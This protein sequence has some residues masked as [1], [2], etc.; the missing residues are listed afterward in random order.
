MSLKVEMNKKKLVVILVT[1]ALFLLMACEINATQTE[2]MMKH[3]SSKEK[4]VQYY[5]KNEKVAGSIDLITTTKG[6]KLLVTER[7]K[8]LL[9]IGQLMKDRKGYY[10]SKITADTLLNTESVG[11]ELDTMDDHK[12][13]IYFTKTNDNS[14]FILL[15]N[16]EFYFSIEE[17][18]TICKEEVNIKNAILKVE[19]VKNI[20]YEK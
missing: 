15:P 17:G 11:W 4:A 13:T 19:N 2:D 3:F 9:F 20:D 18:H 1:L 8:N 14:D 12:Y 7:S 5:I 16:G 10:V 6:D